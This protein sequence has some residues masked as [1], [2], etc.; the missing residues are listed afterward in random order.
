M[1]LLGQD[2]AKLTENVYN[3]FNIEVKNSQET[4]VHCVAKES[5]ES[6]GKNV[7]HK[8]NNIWKRFQQKTC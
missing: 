3:H 8:M 2:V 5:K 7:L 1:F 6:V 4:R